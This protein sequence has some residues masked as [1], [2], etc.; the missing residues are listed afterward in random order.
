[1]MDLQITS[2]TELTFCLYFM[3]KKDW[4]YTFKSELENNFSSQQ[5][6]ICEHVESTPWQL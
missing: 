6:Q 2:L 5:R 4:K 1:M 3:S